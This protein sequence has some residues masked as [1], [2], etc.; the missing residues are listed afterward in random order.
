VRADIVEAAYRAF[1]ADVDAKPEVTLRA[2][3]S[4]DSYEVPPPFDPELDEPTD[5][6]LEMYGFHGLPFLDPA[7]WR[8]YLP[9]L[10]DYVFRHLDDSQSMVIDGLV[11]SLRPPDR[12]PP[13]LASLNGEQEAVV[14]DFL[15]YLAF[16]EGSLPEH[17]MALQALEEWWVPDA[18]YRPRPRRDA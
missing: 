6:Y 8:H 16:S 11:Y 13:R 5:S 3:D 10:I 12:N 1:R 15:E 2:G 7:S 4:L 14:V 17:E 9:R 18:I